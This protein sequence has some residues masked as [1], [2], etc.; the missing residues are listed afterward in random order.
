[1]TSK[2]EKVLLYSSRIDQTRKLSWQVNPL[3]LADILGRVLSYIYI[4]IY[5]YLFI[6]LFRSDNTNE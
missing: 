1:M 6:Y 4:Y 3:V 5:I 2:V